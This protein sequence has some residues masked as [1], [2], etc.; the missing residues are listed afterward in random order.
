MIRSRKRWDQ[1]GCG[2]WTLLQTHVHHHNLLAEML[3]FKD[4]LSSW[5]GSF[6]I[7]QGFLL[8]GFI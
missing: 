2:V 7:S 1:C 8:L 3:P 4:D 5:E 6:A